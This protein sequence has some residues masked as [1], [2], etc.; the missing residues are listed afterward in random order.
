[1][2]SGSYTVTPIEFGL[3]IDVMK[4]PPGEY[5]ISIIEGGRRVINEMFNFTQPGQQDI[6]HLKPCTEY[7]H[8][9]AFIQS[10]GNKTLQCNSTGNKTETKEMSEYK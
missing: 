4:S 2:C 1:M 10:D 8:Q 3:Q 5:D 9:V 6:Q 7:E